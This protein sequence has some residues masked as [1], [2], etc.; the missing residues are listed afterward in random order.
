M[1]SLQ[2]VR[3]TNQRLN[4][5]ILWKFQKASNVGKN[6]AIQRDFVRWW[7]GYFDLICPPKYVNH[8]W[9]VWRHARTTCKLAIIIPVFFRWGSPKIQRKTSLHWNS[10]TK[11]ISKMFLYVFMLLAASVYLCHKAK[12]RH[13]NFIIISCFV[14]AVAPSENLPR[15]KPRA[16]VH[17]TKKILFIQNFRLKNFLAFFLLNR[18]RIKGYHLLRCFFNCFD[19]NIVFLTAMDPTN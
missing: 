3:D 4:G 9:K 6:D 11:K 17:R 16:S 19:Q 8:T 10:C 14:S 2:V 1:G 12:A 18:L 15:Q 7:I 13:Y 5:C